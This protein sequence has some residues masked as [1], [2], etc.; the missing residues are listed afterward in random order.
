MFNRTTRKKSHRGAVRKR[1]QQT[2]Y[3]LLFK[4][5]GLV[6]ALV[7][8]GSSAWLL[9]D[10]QP[11]TFMPVEHVAIEGEFENL[12]KNDMQT[13]VVDV[14]TGGYFTVDLKV[15]RETLLNLP[16]VEEVSVRRQWPSGLVIRV[17]EKH[18]V[19]YWGTDSLIS[20]KGEMFT[21]RSLKH[22]KIM[23]QLEGP[24]GQHKKVWQFAAQ[25]SMQLQALGLQ[26]EKVSLDERRAWRIFVATGI[27]DAQAEKPLVEINLGKAE[28]AQRLNRFLNVFAMR[29]APD[30]SN[31]QVVDMRYPNGF[32]MR[33]IH[34]KEIDA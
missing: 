32:A 27:Q 19:A 3:A 16:W 21:P 2:D 11:D 4:R 5:A 24:E 26:T 15:I 34:K 31:V 8:L 25:V 29:N 9:R 14:L 13:H 20:D 7:V 10:Y 12:A 1:Q 33:S 6:L 18:A 22:E 28:T 23:L 30:L 17:T